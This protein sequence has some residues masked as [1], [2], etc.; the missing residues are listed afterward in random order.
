MLPFDIAGQLVL[1]RLPTPFSQDVAFYD[2]ATEILGGA[3]FDGHW[4]QIGI[5]IVEA[6]IGFSWSFVVTYLIVAAIDC[7]PGFEVL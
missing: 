7:V 2:G 4:E 6:L 3:V 1:I 5:Q